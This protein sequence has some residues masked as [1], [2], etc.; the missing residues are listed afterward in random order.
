MFESTQRWQIETEL[1]TIDLRLATWQSI[2]VCLQQLHKNSQT[3]ACF[4]VV[5]CPSELLGEAARL[6]GHLGMEDHVE[7]TSA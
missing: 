1:K 2:C 6:V 5:V 4:A 7:L 3:S